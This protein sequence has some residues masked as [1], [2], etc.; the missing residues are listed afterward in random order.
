MQRL[1][2]EGFRF[3]CGESKFYSIKAKSFE[4]TDESLF[5]QA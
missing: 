5:L 2:L 4:G 1:A 3:T